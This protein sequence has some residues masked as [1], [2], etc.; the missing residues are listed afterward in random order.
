[1]R[2]LNVLDAMMGM[3]KTTAMIR[4]INE[5][6]DDRPIIFCTPL[7]PQVERVQT[8]CTQRHIVAPS[9]EFMTKTA[10]IKVLI[11]A[12]L[13][14]ATTHSLFLRFDE[15]IL[16]LI[17]ERHYTL[18]VDEAMDVLSL[19]EISG[20]DAETILEK[21]CTVLDDGQLVWTEQDYDG[22]FEQY[23]CDIDT[24][25]V[26]K[27]GKTSLIRMCKIEAFEVF[28][29]VFVMT[30]LFEGHPCKAYFDFNGWT[31]KQ[32]Y[33]GGDTHE[34]YHLSETPVEYHHPDYK[35]LITIKHH[36]NGSNLETGKSAFSLKWFEENCRY[37]TAQ[38]AALKRHLATF[39]RQ[40]G[41]DGCENNMWTSFKA[42]RDDLKGSRYANGF[43]PCNSKATNEFRHKTVL[44]YPIN[45]YMNPHLV[46]FIS[47]YGGKL[48]HNDYALT[49]MVQWVW[50]SAIRDGKPIIIYIPSDR[51]YDIFTNW[52]NGLNT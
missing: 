14:I 48:K 17:R 49:E 27:Y 18:I 3:G 42:F 26:F 34:T 25:T 38:F 37:E 1:M 33:V 44:A 20:Y 47:K 52:L 40:H 32:W 13:N 6:P 51:M 24:G 50:R 19:Y 28:D 10:N 11:Q 12:G 45:R 39:F 30:Y 8:G 35:T 7:L 29:E 23:K 22:A 36:F 46:N 31:Y 16:E 43:V 41:G 21:Y 2:T 9:D 15:E 5:L 4:Y